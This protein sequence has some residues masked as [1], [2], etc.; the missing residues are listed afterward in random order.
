MPDW[1]PEIRRHFE[2]LD[3][4]PAD[5]AN[6]TEE[7]QQ[8]LDD[9]Y[10]DLRSRGIPDVDARRGALEELGENEVFR[11]HLRGVLRRP[12]HTVPLGANEGRGVAGIWGDLRFGARMLRRAPG[13]TVTAAL[14]IA[15]GI[16]ANTTIFSLMNVLLL[17]PLPGTV[18]SDE[19]VLLGRTQEGQGFDTFSYPDYLDY[20]A[21]ARSLSAVAAS[22]VAPAHL[23]TGGASER[24][25]A[26]LVSGNYFTALG[27]RASAGRL[28]T[29]SDDGAPGAN[30]VVVLSHATWQRRFGADPN[31]IGKSVRVSGAPLTVVGVAEPGFNGV[32]TVGIV[33]LFVPISMGDGL[34]PEFDQ[35]LTRRG[36]V[37]LDLFGRLAP[38]ATVATAQAELRSIAADLTERYPDTN[39]GRGVRVSAG[40]G[41][42]PESR[43]QVR[44]FLSML[45]GVVALVLLIACANVANLLLARG[46]VRARELAVRASLGASRSRLVRQL[47]AE[48]FVLAL[49]GGAAGFVL[50][51]WS[52]RLVLRLPVFANSYGAVTPS[53]DPRVLAFTIGAMVASGVLFA[54]PPA[55]RTSRVDL[56]TALKLGMPGSGDGRSRLRTGLVALQLA[57]SLVLLVG[58]GLFVRTLQA[59]YA[60]DPGFETRHVLVATVDAGLEGYDEPRGR[61]LFEELEERVRSVPGVQHAAM[62]YMLPL[63]GGGWDTR[64][65][66]AES[67]ATPDDPGLKAD[68]NAVSPSYFETLGMSLIAGRGFMSAD[69]EGSPGVAVVND[70]IA[71]TLWPGR[72]PIGQRFRIGRTDEVL[73]VVGLV[74]RA[75]YRSLVEAPRPFFYRPFAQ[76][77]RPSMTLHVRTASDD[78]YTVLPSVRRALDELDRDLPLSRVRT[79]AERV[80]GSLG[81]QRTAAALVGA[82]GFLA[83]LLAAIGLYGSMSYAVSRRTREMGVRMALGARASEVLWHVLAQALRVA[84]AGTVIGLV[85]AVPATRIL[86]AQLY[87]VS[88][89]DPATLAAVTLILAVVSLAAAYLPARRATNVDPVVALRSE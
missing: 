62:G 18:R 65:F 10:H 54:L 17:R 16:G 47:L 9:R 51:V 29:M 70:V 31:V 73:E 27:T 37:W 81:S 15:L 60:I 52:V 68:V 40:L 82:Y 6:V 41:F 26:E 55:F 69:R 58:A 20:R 30:R 75:R 63:G 64:I 66:V 86:R 8:H 13:F 72:D 88:A 71:T 77:Y 61:R 22:F 12:R 45:L 38:N 67:P 53:V 85:A 43:A 7:L 49:L 36:A 28:L 76:V 25:R 84:L 23:S 59:L 56:V 50:G 4:S 35:M 78:P 87:G 74:R 83:L 48:G 79:L 42:D 57:L 24:V 3:L 5:E 80:D 33:D 39:R 44:Q 2:A 32:R 14:T 46:S 1:T 21:A 34:L 11:N 19:L 89:I